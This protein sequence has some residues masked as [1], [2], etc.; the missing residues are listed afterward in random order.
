VADPAARLVSGHIRFVRRPYQQTAPL[1]PTLPRPKE[2]QSTQYGMLA[3]SL[4]LTAAMSIAQVGLLAVFQHSGELLVESAVIVGTDLVGN[5]ARQVFMMRQRSPEGYQQSLE[6]YELFVQRRLD[7]ERM[8]L[9]ERFPDPA[10]LNQAAVETHAELWERRP[11]TPDFLKVRVGI[12]S[13]SSAL[14]S[15]SGAGAQPQPGTEAPYLHNV[16]VT[17]DV[18]GLRVRQAR[19]PVR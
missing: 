10:Q 13:V 1:L 19:I 17:V 5:G 16:P 8:Q 2:P 15:E 18:S 11:D 3:T 7:Q 9:T 4:G 14:A 6:E 12:G